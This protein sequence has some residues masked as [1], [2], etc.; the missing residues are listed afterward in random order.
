MFDIFIYCAYYTF[1]FVHVQS[2]LATTVFLFHYFLIQKYNLRCTLLRANEGCPLQS[3]VMLS[4]QLHNVCLTRGL[5]SGTSF[6]Q[7]LKETRKEV[8]G[9]QR[10]I[11]TISHQGLPTPSK[12]TR[13]SPF[14]SASLRISLISLLVTC[15]PISFFM[16][17][18]SSVKLIWPSPLESNWIQTERNSPF[19]HNYEYSSIIYLLYLLCF[20]HAFVTLITENIKVL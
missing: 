5:V 4:Q 11:N 3:S 19:K 12:S 1:K 20:A 13:P 10:T 15:S 9:K 17:S 18:R 8:R 16:A 2:L 6:A 7:T 14:R